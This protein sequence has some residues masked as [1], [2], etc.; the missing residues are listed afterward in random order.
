[1]SNKRR[2]SVNKTSNTFSKLYMTTESN[3]RGNLDFENIEL[4]CRQNMHKVLGLFCFRKPVCYN[5]NPMAVHV[6]FL[7]IN[8]KTSSL[9]ILIHVSVP[10]FSSTKFKIY[11]GYNVVY[12]CGKYAVLPKYMIKFLEHPLNCHTLDL[13][14][15][16]VVRCDKLKVR[17]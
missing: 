1:M 7:F 3:I 4:G 16:V 8:S 9:A 6:F 12:V 13:G 11:T 5:Q 2:L 10:L 15:R 14:I 17:M